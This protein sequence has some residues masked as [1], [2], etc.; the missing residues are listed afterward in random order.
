M[1]E[2]IN[3]PLHTGSGIA[4]TT[5]I[6]VPPEKDVVFYNDDYTT[7]DFVVN[8]L[9]SVFN[10]SRENAE[11]IMNTVHEKGSAIVGTYT[12]D[13]AVSRTNLTRSIAKQNGFPLRVEVE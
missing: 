11:L 12:Y 2:F 9:V 1:S 6:E 8:V 7:M 10:K 13:I 5:S 4:E 3:Q